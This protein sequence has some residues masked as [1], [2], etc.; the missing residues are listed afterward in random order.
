MEIKNIQ[1]AVNRL[2]EHRKLG[3]VDIEELKSKSEE[4]TDRI[5]ILAS[6]GSKIERNLEDV[7]DAL[8]QLQ[9]GKK[10]LFMHDLAI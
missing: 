8:H 7:M 1:A 3:L 9:S 4:F 6:T 5:K 10:L 2:E